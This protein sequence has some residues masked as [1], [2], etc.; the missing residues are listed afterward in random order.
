[1]TTYETEIIYCHVAVCIDRVRSGW[2]QRRFQRFKR[3]SSG[4]QRGTCG[5][6]SAGDSSGDQ[7][8]RLF[9][10]SNAALPAGNRRAARH[11]FLLF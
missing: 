9:V 7:L 11:G 10:R 3:D 4:D 6:R 8:I 5:P 2:L 1:L